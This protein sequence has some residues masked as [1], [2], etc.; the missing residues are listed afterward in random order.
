MKP[1][2]K[3]CGLTRVCDVAAAAAAGADFI[4]VVIAA[5]SPR[6]VATPA[7]VRALFDAAPDGVT[8]VLVSAGLPHPELQRW[9]DATAP[10]AVQLH[11]SEPAEYAARLYGV[12][13]WKAFPVLTAADV[14]A[15]VEFPCETVVADGARG[16]SG[17]C[18]DWTLAAELCRRRRVL[19]AGGLTPDN[20][21]EALR[22]TGAAG[23]DVSGGVE[24]APG[25]KSEIQIKKLARRIG[26]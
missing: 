23:I 21:S 10:D 9:I 16:G 24:S 19:L 2:L 11:G 17:V 26:K 8:T 3:I 7:A 14:A 15:A 12:R 1:L 22:V 4:G 25:I 6:R 5:G 13:V 20:V 18:C